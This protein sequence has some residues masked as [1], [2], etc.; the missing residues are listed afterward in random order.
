VDGLQL[1]E[2]RIEFTVGNKNL[3]Q[4]VTDRLKLGGG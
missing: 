4:E 2:Q 1:A 3:I